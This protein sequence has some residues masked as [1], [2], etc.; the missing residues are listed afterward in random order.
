MEDELIKFLLYHYNKKHEEKKTA[1]TD[2][3]TQR[4][5]TLTKI[6]DDVWGDKP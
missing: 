1:F 3:E 6:I 5:E 4:L 2:E